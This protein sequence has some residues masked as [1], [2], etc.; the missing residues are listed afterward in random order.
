MKKTLKEFLGKVNRNKILTFEEF[1]NLSLQKIKE[2][3]KV[4][5]SEHESMLL[6]YTK[7]NVQRTVRILKTFKPN[8]KLVKI[9]TAINTPQR[10]FAI[11]EDWCGDSAQNLPYFAKY[12]ELNPNI[13]FNIILRDM[14]LDL[15]DNYFNVGNPRSIPKVVAF[16]SK[17]EEIFVWGARPKVAQALVTKLKN[18]G[19]SKEEFNKKL[20][21][22]YAK[23]KGKELEKE[24]VSLLSN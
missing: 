20:H 12:A 7:I 8:N 21:L 9:I 13:E 16:N 14:N 19:F 22:W 6:S 1:N 23:N 18:D 4:T 24:L 3:E 15:V 5:L 2:L 11:T 10:W 17:E